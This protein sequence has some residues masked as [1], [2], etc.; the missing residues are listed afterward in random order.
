MTNNIET[1]LVGLLIAA[2]LWIIGAKIRGALA[3]T[4][5]PDFARTFFIRFLVGGAGLAIAC[6][7]VGLLYR[8]HVIGLSVAALLYAPIVVLFGV[9]IRRLQ[10]YLHE[11]EGDSNHER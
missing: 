9:G 11:G 5:G 7:V 3:A 1:A 4:R 6:F 2:A 10:P 8:L